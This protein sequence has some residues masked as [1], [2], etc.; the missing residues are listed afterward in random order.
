MLGLSRQTPPSWYRDRVREELQE[1][2]SAESFCQK[3]SETSDVFFPLSRAQYDGFPVRKLPEFVAYHHGLVYSYMIT[4]Y[5]LRWSF[6]RTAAML[7]NVPRYDL[8]RE[9]VASRHQIDPLEYKRPTGSDAGSSSNVKPVIIGIYGIPGSGKT[10][11]LNQLQ[12]ELEGEDFNLTAGGLRAFQALEES[13]KQNQRKLAID[14]IRNECVESKN[15]EVVT[16]HYMFWPEGGVERRVYTPNDLDTF[17]HIIYMTVAPKLVMEQ[18]LKDTRSRPP[19]SIEHLKRWQE[20]EQTE[21]LGLCYE[22]S[23]LFTHR[24]ELD[25]ILEAAGGQGKLYT[26]VVFDA[27]RTLAA[28]DSG[29]LFWEK[30]DQA[31][32]SSPMGYSYTAFRQAALLYEEAVDNIEHITALVVTC[33]LRLVWEKVL[34]RQGLSNTVNVI[35]SGQAGDAS[36]VTPA[37]KAALVRRFRNTFKT[38]VWAFGDSVLDLPMLQAADV[39]IVVV[40]EEHQRGKSMD[41]PLLDAINKGLE[42]HQLVIPSTASCRLDSGKLPLVKSTIEAFISSILLGRS[43]RNLS[44]VR[45]GTGCNSA[46]LL[47][48]PTRDSKVA[49]P[50]L[51]EAHRR[52]AIPHVQGHETIGYRLCHEGQT[53]IVALMR[54]GEPMAMG[55][56]DAFPLAMFMHASQPSHVTPHHLEG[57]RTVLLVDSMVNSGKAATGFIQHVHKL[58]STVQIVVVAG[59]VQVESIRVGDL[60][61]ELDLRRNVSLIVLRLS[62]NKFTGEGTTDTGNRLFNTTRLDG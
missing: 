15:V 49:S 28:E 62:D 50:I 38:Y 3:V 22:H 7:C 39:P 5:T 19:M 44:R 47:M 61:A 25:E 30:L 10:F 11:L 18:L 29:T 2:R 17:T 16:G 4:K 59:V 45:H 24:K 53:L 1:R 8:V 12:K 26:V 43:E 37:V 27:D 55:V 48:T 52:Y 46:K 31:L 51:R 42:A 54:G 36:I 40:G 56:N 21:L 14:W 32:F 58:D 33:G 34:E 23:I 35:G 20:T 13:S 57:Q 41:Q 60:A 6:Y 9:V